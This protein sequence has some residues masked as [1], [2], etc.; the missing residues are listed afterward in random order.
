MGSLAPRLI[1]G[2]VGHHRLGPVSHAFLTPAFYLQIPLKTMAKEGRGRAGNWAWGINRPA[3][4]S[5][6]DKD[7]GDGGP[8]LT[9][10]QQVLARHGIA[11][12]GGEIWLST[13]PRMLGYVFKPVSFWFCTDGDGALAAVIVEVNNTFGD[14]H[15]YVLNGADYK[16]GQ[17][18]EAQKAFYVS[19]FFP[20]TG[21]YR[22]RFLWNGGGPTGRDL[23]RIEYHE[24]DRPSLIT[25]MSGQ[26]ELLTARR[27]VLAWLRYPAFS[28]GVILKI[29]WHALLLWRKGL[30]LVPR[31]ARSS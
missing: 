3:L 23:A 29:H 15:V 8:L 22:F 10:A 16:N 6:H 31:P 11:D 25:H 27:A 28:L 24:A 12:P 14:R 7:H 26:A 2:L 19:P 1:T 17:T 21:H 18:L 5:V 13:F 30:R 4:L 9:W 20:V